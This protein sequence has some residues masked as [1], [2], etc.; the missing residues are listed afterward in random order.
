MFFFYSR[1]RTFNDGNQVY[2]Q[3]KSKLG[4]SGGN[5]IRVCCALMVLVVPLNHRGTTDSGML[6][7]CLL[8]VE[9]RPRL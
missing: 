2:F 9:L 8:I 3:E 6:M 5:R 7:Y 4:A 1:P